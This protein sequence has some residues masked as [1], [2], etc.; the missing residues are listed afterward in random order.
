MMPR[1]RFTLMSAIL[2]ANAVAEQYCDSVIG[3]VDEPD[4]ECDSLELVCNNRLSTETRLNIAI[5]SNVIDSSTLRSACVAMVRNQHIVHGSAYDPPE[6]RLAQQFAD[7]QMHDLSLH[8]AH[9]DYC[10]ALSHRLSANFLARAAVATL[11]PNATAA[12]S[13]IKRY[14]LEG[15]GRPAIDSFLLEIG[16]A[17]SSRTRVM[18]L[19]VCRWITPARRSYDIPIE[20]Q[21]VHAAT[22]KDTTKD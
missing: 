6:L 16:L 8:I 12:A 5:Y 2:S 14:T 18:Q 3:P 20:R 22:S 21:V 19:P 17:V 13:M 15:S 4:V 9:S 10:E 1:Q 7:G 11:A